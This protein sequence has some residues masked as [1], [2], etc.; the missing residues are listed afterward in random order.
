MKTMLSPTDGRFRRRYLSLL[1]DFSVFSSEWKQWV[2]L[3]LDRFPGFL[4]FDLYTIVLGCWRAGEPDLLRVLVRLEIV[5]YDVL[6]DWYGLAR[7]E[8]T[9]EVLMK[10]FLTDLYRHFGREEYRNDVLSLNAGRA[11]DVNRIR[12]LLMESDEDIF[13]RLGQHFDVVLRRWGWVSKA[14]RNDA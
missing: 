3:A 6:I 2:G 1:D 10:L 5:W 8:F 12:H 7:Q 14:L 13:R 4:C 11:V 9:P